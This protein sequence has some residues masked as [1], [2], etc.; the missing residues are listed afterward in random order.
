MGVQVK[1][2]TQFLAEAKSVRYVSVWHTPTTRAGGDS[3]EHLI[4]VLKE[5][6]IPARKGY[7]H[8]VDK[9]SVDVP[10]KHEKRAAKIAYKHGT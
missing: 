6:G 4:N 1:T 8:F 5:K 9:V 10:E 2:F 7:S 3:G